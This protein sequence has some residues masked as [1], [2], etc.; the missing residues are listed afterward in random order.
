MSEEKRYHTQPLFDHNEE[1]L[2]KSIK[3]GKI[4]C[5]VDEHNG[6]IV[7]YVMPSFKLEQLKQEEK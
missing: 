3:E 2:I 4:Q 1:D 5:L 6:G 7:A